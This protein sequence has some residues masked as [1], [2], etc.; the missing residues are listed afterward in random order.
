[1]VLLYQRYAITAST[2]RW[3]ANKGLIRKMS[4]V[5]FQVFN[6]IWKEEGVWHE[7]VVNREEPLQTTDYHAENILLCEMLLNEIR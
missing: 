6:L 1:M 3:L 7:A 2:T 4:H 5:L